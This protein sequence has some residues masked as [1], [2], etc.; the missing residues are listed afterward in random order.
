L[1]STPI[2]SLPDNLT[3]RGNLELSNTPISSLP[4][5]LTVEGSLYIISTPISEKYTKEQ[6]KQMLPGIKGMIWR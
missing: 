3:V 2:E 4:N 1:V 6:L 5:N